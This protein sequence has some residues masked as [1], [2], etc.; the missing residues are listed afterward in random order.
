MAQFKKEMKSARIVDGIEMNKNQFARFVA[1]ENGKTITEAKEW[2]DIFIQSIYDLM[3]LHRCVKF[4][5]FG[6]FYVEEVFA[7]PN[8]KIGDRH[9]PTKK[10]YRA[11]F[12]M[13]K[14]L[15]NAPNQLENGKIQE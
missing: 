11:K 12:R 10:R 2:A 15:K 9:M 4:N 1:A 7:N 8:F 5:E 14:V 6:T 13:G 3:V